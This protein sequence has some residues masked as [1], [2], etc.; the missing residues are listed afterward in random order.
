[1]W[2]KN[3]KHFSSKNDKQGCQYNS[4]EGKSFPSTAFEWNDEG[5]ETFKNWMNAKATLLCSLRLRWKVLFKNMA[6]SSNTG[7]RC[8][9]SP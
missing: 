5:K 8:D 7:Q 1:M 6:V 3:F 9:V 2:N 4:L